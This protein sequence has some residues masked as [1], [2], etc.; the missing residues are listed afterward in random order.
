VQR[1]QLVDLGLEL[2]HRFFEIEIA[3]HRLG[4]LDQIDEWLLWGAAANSP[5]QP[6]GVKE[7]PKTHK[8]LAILALSQRV[9]VAH[10]AFEALLQNM[11]IDLGR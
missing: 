11:G 3:A 6:T 5:A 7:W 2:G 4:Q 1:A 10:Q 8:I 9:Q